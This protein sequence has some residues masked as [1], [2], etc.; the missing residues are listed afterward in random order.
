MIPVLDVP[1]AVAAVRDG[2]PVIIP[3]ETVYGLAA[4]ALDPEAVAKI[5]QVKGR[6]Q[7][8]PIICHL[9]SAEA[10]FRYG[11]PSVAAERLSRFWPGPLTILLAHENRIPSIVTAGSPLAGFRVPAHPLTLEFLRGC[12]VPIA[13]PSANRS[14]RRSPTT[15]TM[16]Q[17]DYAQKDY[18]REDCAPAK[19]TNESGETRDG[20]D[21]ATMIAGVLDGGPCQVGL[22]STVV[23]IVHEDP[24]TIRILRPG[25]IPAED[26]ARAGFRIESNQNSFSDRD[27]SASAGTSSGEPALSYDTANATPL[28]APGQLLQH[29]GPGVPLLLLRRA[30]TTPPTEKLRTEI[31]GALRNL[32]PQALPIYWLGF[33]GRP[34]PVRCDHTLDLSTSGDFAEAARNLFAYFD[35]ISGRGSGII[36]S[37]TLPEQG[38]GVAINDRLTRAATELI[39]ELQ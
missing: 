28:H 2:N 21:P 8:N 1:Q 15:V 6:P 7:F 26:L 19:Y 25:G 14:G 31:E 34:A 33:A 35:R 30:T 12:E 37:E 32:N 38:L 39:P 18:A 16:V 13:A 27:A 17:E 20:L 29:Y 36:L 5:F 3:T 9:D 10:V 22:E 11:R 24:P 23:A 4:S